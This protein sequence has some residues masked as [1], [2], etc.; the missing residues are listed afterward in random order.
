MQMTERL[1]LGPERPSTNA[2]P[3]SSAT[4]L[5]MIDGVARFSSSWAPLLEG[6]SPAHWTGSYWV[7]ED[8]SQ[9]YDTA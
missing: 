5:H 8:D 2:R 1:S 9:F 3:P 6:G 4:E 7:A